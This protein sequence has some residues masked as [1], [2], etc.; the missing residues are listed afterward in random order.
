MPAVPARSEQAFGRCWRT[1]LCA[2]QMWWSFP[3]IGGNRES[4]C[5]S[6]GRFRTRETGM[7]GKPSQGALFIQAPL[8]TGRNLR[9]NVIT[10]EQG[11]FLSGTGMDIPQNRECS[12]AK[13]G[14]FSVEAERAPLLGPARRNAH[15]EQLVEC[16]RGGLPTFQ[17]GLLDIGSEKNHR[18]EPA[19]VAADRRPA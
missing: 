4:R 8:P 6:R 17:D 11:S 13:Q 3:V 10:P 5:F 16:K 18:P 14:S 9:G 2:N 12:R 7:A 15:P 1:S 19:L